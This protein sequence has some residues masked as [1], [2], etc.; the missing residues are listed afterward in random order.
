M[1]WI[2]S[3]EMY[4]IWDK[5]GITEMCSGLIDITGFRE[6]NIPTQS[7][8]T[9]TLVIVIDFWNEI[10]TSFDLQPHK[11]IQNMLIYLISHW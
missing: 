11:G 2:G 1:G 8:S 6:N 5:F 3:T 10:G 7:L 9:T 4:L